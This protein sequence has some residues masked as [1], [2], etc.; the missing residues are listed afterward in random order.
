MTIDFSDLLG[1]LRSDGKLIISSVI[2]AAAGKKVVQDVREDAN[3]VEI[4]LE[5]EVGAISTAT[6]QKGSAVDS[7]ARSSA[8]SAQATATGAQTEI[9]DHETNHPSGVANFADLTGMIADSQIPAAIMRDAEFTAAAVRG[10]L[11][12]T[13]TEVNDIFVG[14]S[15]AGQVLTYTQNDGTTVMITVPTATP[16]QGDGVVQSGAINGTELI[17][18]LDGG[19]TVTIDIDALAT[20]TELAAYATIA[21]LAAHEAST[22]NVDSTARSEALAAQQLITGHQAASTAHATEIQALINATSLSALQGQVTDGQIPAAIMR[23]AELTAAAVRTLLALTSNEVNDLL[24]GATIA[25]QILSFTQNDGSTVNI[26]IPTA[27]PGEGDG[28]VQSGAFNADQ[29]ELILTL[30][31]GGTIT[32]DVPAALRGTGLTAA[33][34]TALSAG[35]TNSNTEIPS[36]HSG[37]LGKISI[38]NIRAY[39]ES[40]VGLG[41]RINPGPSLERAGQVP[42]VNAAGDA[43]ELIEAGGVSVI[44]GPVDAEESLLGRLQWNP[45]NSRVE[46]CENNGHTVT[47]TEGTWDYI[48]DRAEFSVERDR[49]TTTGQSVGDYIYDVGSDHF[50]NWVVVG[51][52]MGNQVLGWRQ[53]NPSTALA[54]SRRA[55]TG[56]LLHWLGDQPSDAVA[57]AVLGERYRS[58]EFDSTDTFYLRNDTIRRLETYTEA[59]T[60]V[61]HWEFVPVIK[62]TVPKP[63]PE[64]ARE[65]VVVNPDGTGH[66]TAHLPTRD[67]SYPHVATLPTATATSPDLVYLEHDYSEG[68]SARTPLSA[69]GVTATWRATA[70]AGLGG[71]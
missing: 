5:D 14:A 21:A 38:A 56:I 32:I 3:A 53:V 44:A 39:M 34:I 27:T 31:A 15:I 19:G 66:T 63:T 42:A 46:I 64:T 65:A 49:H 67:D 43:Y 69:S 4:D 17:L 1:S 13:A 71:Q 57:L 50:Y 20:D 58:Y 61:D 70:T 25:G 54:L 30:A 48:A 35:A 8:A 16:G 59:G 12:L 51:V 45:A 28:V 9:D 11:G 24:T 33:A 37:D 40:S 23:D 62:Y 22:H 52:D 68:Q 7:A 60:Y 10:L 6:I 29:T 47:A 18:T 26:T 2:K 55:G 41:P 36:V